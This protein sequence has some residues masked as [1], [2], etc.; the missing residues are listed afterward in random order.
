MQT[1]ANEET[2]RNELEDLKNLVKE[3]K[4]L[5]R[6]GNLELYVKYSENGI[7]YGRTD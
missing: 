3:K 2:L 1:E 6:V 4:E 7:K 5:E